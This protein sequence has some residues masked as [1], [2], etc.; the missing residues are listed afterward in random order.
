MLRTG[1]TLLLVLSQ[2]AAAAPG[3]LDPRVAACPVPVLAIDGDN[4]RTLADANGLTIYQFAR[5]NPGLTSCALKPGQTYCVDPS[6]HNLLADGMTE[7]TETPDGSCA[8]SG[9]HS[10]TG[11]GWGDCCAASG[12]CGATEEYCGAGC[13][14]DYGLCGSST[15]EDGHC[16]PIT[17]I[18]TNFQTIYLRDTPSGLEQC[19][20]ATVL[21]VSY[22][23]DT[24]T[25]YTSRPL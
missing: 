24:V 15:P 18:Q 21:T 5:S 8:G 17:V 7:W 12:W 3:V 13:N 22:L 1:L 20:S 19:P 2:Y 14:P 23:Y 16:V 4:C 11:S 9:A 6:I 10:C 25:V